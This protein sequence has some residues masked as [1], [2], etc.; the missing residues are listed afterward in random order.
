MGKEDSYGIAY[1]S[2]P[3]YTGYIYVKYTHGRYI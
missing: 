1:K 3:L 2:K